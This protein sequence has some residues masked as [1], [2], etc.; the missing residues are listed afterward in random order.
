MN[1]D[2]SKLTRV[3][4]VDETGRV[5][6]RTDL[7]VVLSVQDDGRTLKVFAN[8]RDLGTQAD[9]A[10]AAPVRTSNV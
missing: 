9:D 8:R 3:T 1:I 6:E 4:L 7:A 5:Y 2:T 10:V